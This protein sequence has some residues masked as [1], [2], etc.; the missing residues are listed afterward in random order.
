MLGTSAL[1]MANAAAV[2][3]S[4]SMRERVDFLTKLCRRAQLEQGYLMKVRGPS[5]LIDC[6]WCDNS[7][8]LG[9]TRTL[10]ISAVEAS[11]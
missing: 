10:V 4:R 3:R 5:Q 1:L 9:Q 2:P 7:L 6:R 11:P 8:T